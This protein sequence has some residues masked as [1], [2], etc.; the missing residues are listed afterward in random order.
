MIIESQFKPAWWLKSAHI[1]TI[2]PTL[3]RRDVSLSLIEER[4][5][6]HDGDFVDLV[7]A[8]DN[9]S[10]NSPLVILLHGLGG[11]IQSPYAKGLMFQF[12]RHGWRAVLMHFRGCSGEPNRLSRA[13]HSGDTDD[14]DYL[15]KVLH[16]RMSDAPLAAVGISL[17]GSVLLKWLGESR[18]K[19]QLEAAVAVSVPF[20][21][22][23]AATHMTTGF[24]KLYQIYIVKELHHYMR[25]KFKVEQAPF[26]LKQ[27]DKWR[28]F[29]TFDDNITA[30]LHGFVHVHDYYTHASARNYLSTIK[31]K[32]LIIHSSDDPFMPPEVIP[33]GHELSEAIQFELADRGGHVGFITGN[34]PGYPEYWLE[35]RI[36]QFFEEINFGC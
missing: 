10:A 31:T 26:D 32:T 7:W 4:L 11:S 36:P 17:G 30:P 13:Y 16:Q 2:L 23:L 22:R 21:L 14:F 35:Q 15:L 5:E 18:D 28:C 1:Q 20:D 9:L 27:M 19:G 3:I 25:Q 34:I 33:A 8:E 6:L 24:A 29:W 12:N